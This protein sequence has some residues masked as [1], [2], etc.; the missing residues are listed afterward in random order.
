[1]SVTT[2]DLPT[3]AGFWE[4]VDIEARKK[5][6]LLADEDS[7]KKQLAERA[8]DKQRLLESSSNSICC[9]TGSRGRRAP[10][11]N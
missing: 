5:A 3:L 7:Y 9:R 4:G 11:R 1:V 2:H 10:C 6:G 8:R